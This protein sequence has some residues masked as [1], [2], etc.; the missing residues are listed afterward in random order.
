MPSRVELAFKQH[1]NDHLIICTIPHSGTSSLH[2]MKPEYRTTHCG[3]EI[4]KECSKKDVDLLTTY[5]DPKRI[6][7]SWYNRG[8]LGS[9]ADKETWRYRWDSYRTLL[10]TAKVYTMNDL[11]CK[12]NTVKD[13]YGLHAMLDNND[14]DKYYSIIDKDLIDHAYDCSTGA[15]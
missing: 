1:E 5:R 12:L 2:E 15:R 14:M 9:E 4:I 8:L 13:K 7:A 3:K 11:N 10:N 6:A